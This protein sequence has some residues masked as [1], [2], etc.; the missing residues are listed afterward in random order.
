MW[1]SSVVVLDFLNPYFYKDLG[2]ENWEQ[3]FRICAFPCRRREDT[4]LPMTGEQSENAYTGQTHV[5]HPFR[6]PRLPS[7]AWE[8]TGL[9]SCGHRMMKSWLW[10]LRTLV[11]E[12]PDGWDGEGTE[13]IYLCYQVGDWSV[14]RMSQGNRPWGHMSLTSTLPRFHSHTLALDQILKNLAKYW[15]NGNEVND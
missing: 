14:L 10:E 9:S 15:H 12:R 5:Q 7:V 8:L 11:P 4:F 6:A 2:L 3:R 13:V 1:T